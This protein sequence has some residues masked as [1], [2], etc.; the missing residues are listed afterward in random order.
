M[1]LRINE[2]V[3]I[4]RGMRCELL[5]MSD[6]GIMITSIHFHIWEQDEQRQERNQL[7]IVIMKLA[8][9]LDIRAVQ[10]LL[11]VPESKG[12]EYEKLKSVNIQLRICMV[13]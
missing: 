3:L 5:L 8:V 12:R 6:G 4:K 1:Y 7:H 9:I 13:E 11:L 10:F 2:C